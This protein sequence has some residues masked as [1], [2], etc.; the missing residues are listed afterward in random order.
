[1]GFVRNLRLAG[2]AG[3]LLEAPRNY[4]RYYESVEEVLGADETRDFARLFLAPGM[5]HCGGGPSPN[6]LDELS[7]HEAWV[8]KKQSPQRIVA[9][10]VTNGRTDRTRP[11]CPYPQVANYKDSGSI[12][13]EAN[14]T[15]RLPAKK[16]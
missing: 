14:F 7:A 15:Y 6:T 16:E 8:E 13:E 12:D 2:A 10:H 1:M 4:I 9:S 3:L 11:L 5:G